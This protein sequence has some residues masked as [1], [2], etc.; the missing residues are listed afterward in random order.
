VRA[1]TDP[2]GRTEVANFLIAEMRKKGI[3]VHLNTTIAGVEKVGSVQHVRLSDGS[4]VTNELPYPKGHEKLPMTSAEV[5]DK[6]RR[7]FSGYGSAQSAD[8]VIAAVDALDRAT[9]V[10]TLIA[11]FNARSARPTH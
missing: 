3:T 1:L 8:G 2:N 6:F 5:Q 9:D 10:T 11:A 7:L 4:A